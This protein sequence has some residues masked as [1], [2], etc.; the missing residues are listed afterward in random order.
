M[1][2]WDGFISC[3]AHVNAIDEIPVF[4]DGLKTIFNLVAK[5]HPEYGVN[6]KFTAG[7][8]VLHYLIGGGKGSRK[9]P[10]DW[11]GSE[12]L[13]QYYLELKCYPL[14]ERHVRFGT[15]VMTPVESIIIEAWAV[16]LTYAY[17]YHARTG[18]LFPVDLSPDALL[19]LLKRA[20]SALTGAEEVTIG[21]ASENIQIRWRLRAVKEPN[22]I[23][24]D[25]PDGLLGEYL[26]IQWLE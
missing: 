17:S 2:H 23:Y 10:L 7:K 25:W 8:V 3:F 15:P 20:I 18:R 26:R 13:K 21:T 5:H 11:C 19:T 12:V 16:M 6:F 4:E 1:A 9:V 14:A 22:N 24:L